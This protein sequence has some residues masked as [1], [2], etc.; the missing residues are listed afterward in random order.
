MQCM[1]ITNG[2]PMSGPFSKELWNKIIEKVVGK[3]WWRCTHYQSSSLGAVEQWRCLL[4]NRTCLEI[5]AEL[6]HLLTVCSPLVCITDQRDFYGRLWL[7]R[8]ISFNSGF[9]GPG[10][11]QKGDVSSCLLTLWSRHRYKGS[12]RTVR[13]WRTAGLDLFNWYKSL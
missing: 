5:V 6:G 12:V 9:Q 7:L 10:L 1:H 11:F 8:F 4:K 13:T 2:K 3:L